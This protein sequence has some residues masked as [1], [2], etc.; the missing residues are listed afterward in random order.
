MFDW[1]R[2]KVKV[3][4]QCPFCGLD[5]REGSHGQEIPRK[6]GGVNMV[7][8]VVME[9]RHPAKSWRIEGVTTDVAK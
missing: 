3:Q 5:N 7:C 8:T 2:A 1:Q 9:V 6:D 4:H